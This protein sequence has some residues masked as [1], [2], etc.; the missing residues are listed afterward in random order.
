MLES[1]ELVELGGLA[2]LAE[3]GDLVMLATPNMQTRQ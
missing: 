1:A 2:E 3:F